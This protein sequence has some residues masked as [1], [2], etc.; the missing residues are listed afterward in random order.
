MDLGLA[1]SHVFERDDQEPSPYSEREDDPEVLPLSQPKQHNLPEAPEYINEKENETVL[2]TSSEL[3]ERLVNH[4]ENSNSGYVN[5]INPTS[6]SNEWIAK[7]QEIVQE[8]IS[9]GLSVE[10]KLQAKVPS[11]EQEFKELEL[12]LDK[13][14]FEKA[15]LLERENF[16][17]NIDPLPFLNRVKQTR[18]NKNIYQLSVFKNKFIKL[19]F[20]LVS[21]LGTG[22]FGEVW[23]CFI[24]NEEH[25]TKYKTESNYESAF[26]AV[27]FQLDKQG[28]TSP[29]QEFSLMVSNKHPNIVKFLDYLKDC[30]ALI[31]EY[32][33]NGSLNK[34]LEQQTTPISLDL[35]LKF[36]DQLCDGLEYLHD[37]GIFHRD[38]RI[39]NLLLDDDLNLKIADFGIS[40]F[41]GVALNKQ[42][43]SILYIVEGMYNDIANN[44]KNYASIDIQFFGFVLFKFLYFGDI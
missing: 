44:I 34:F 21:H 38:I 41:N 5:E 4:Y 2:A 33:S 17:P 36:A 11:T 12:I 35:A 40:V 3:H 29:C 1:Q 20:R 26:V 7:W 31:M 14:Y 15:L 39:S 30:N 24:E 9:L 37:K 6:N 8:A 43:A 25:K 22:F 32:C 16:P 13:E 18:K 28:I 10:K 19:G 23:K 42:F 27:K